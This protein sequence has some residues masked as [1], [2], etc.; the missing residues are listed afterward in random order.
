MARGTRRPSSLPA[1]Q[2]WLQ[3]M[4]L[5]SPS[6]RALGA[7]PSRGMGRDLMKGLGGPASVH[8]STNSTD[9]L[10]LLR[11]G[12]TCLGVGEEDSG[13]IHMKLAGSRAG[14]LAWTL[15]GGACQHLHP[16]QPRVREKHACV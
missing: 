12:L 15:V 2:A 5:Q 3:S 1:E 13:N 11:G 14:S 7:L 10:V 4:C 9:D 6:V 16:S 8:S